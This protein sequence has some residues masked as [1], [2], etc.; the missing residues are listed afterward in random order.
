MTQERFRVE[1]GQSG[2]RLDK[3]VV[4][5]LPGLGRKGARRLFDEGKIRVNGRRAS[6]GDVAQ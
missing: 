4:T 6:K 5:H 1:P 3:L 2:E